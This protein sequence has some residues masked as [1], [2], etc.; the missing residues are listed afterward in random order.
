MFPIETP[1][2]RVDFPAGA[3]FENPPQGVAAV[4]KPLST[5][6]LALLLGLTGAGASFQII[7]STSGMTSQS[8]L[9]ICSMTMGNHH[10]EWE[11]P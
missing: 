1:M 2:N 7:W 5:G 11:N 9:V 4:A 3:T 10:F 6:G 8:P